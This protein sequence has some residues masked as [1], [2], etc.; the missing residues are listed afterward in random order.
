MIAHIPLTDL[1]VPVQKKKKK[2]HS[3]ARAHV[4]YHLQ[5]RAA[6]SRG[7]SLTRNWL[8]ECLIEYLNQRAVIGRDESSYAN[9]HLVEVSRRKAEDGKPESGC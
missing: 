9:E 4:K 6:R 7:L 1:A 8:A 5:E 2:I 3:G